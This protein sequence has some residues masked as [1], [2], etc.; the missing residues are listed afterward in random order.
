MNQPLGWDTCVWRCIS[1]LRLR[2]DKRLSG[3]KHMLPRRATF[4]ARRLSGGTTTQ[5]FRADNWLPRSNRD[6][7][8]HLATSRQRSR[9]SA[10][11]AADVGALRR[12]LVMWRFPNTIRVATHHDGTRAHAI[13][14]HRSRA[15]RNVY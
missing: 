6:T 2:R 15:D 3:A 13:R 4:R 12:L 10:D 8:L 7:R 1:S 11:T 9:V 14:R 5:A